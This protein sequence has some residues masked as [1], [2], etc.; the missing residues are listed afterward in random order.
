M[1]F[2]VVGKS[3]IDRILHRV[4]TLIVFSNL[5]LCSI[6]LHYGICIRQEQQK[7]EGKQIS[8]DLLVQFE[9]QKLFSTE[10]ATV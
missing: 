5:A 9:V 7:F 8:V 4:N 1:Q 2:F 6:I 3:H 10:I